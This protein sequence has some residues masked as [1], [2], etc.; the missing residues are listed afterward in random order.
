MV[1]PFKLRNARNAKQRARINTFSQLKR[2]KITPM[3]AAQAS[4]VNIQQ[5]IS[6]RCVVLKKSTWCIYRKQWS[7]RMHTRSEVEPFVLYIE[8]EQ[9]SSKSDYGRK[10]MR[11]SMN[12]KRQFSREE[13]RVNLWAHIIPSCERLIEL[14]LPQQQKT[15]VI[16]PYVPGKWSV[17]PLFPLFR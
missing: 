4:M 3:N 16:L 17:N 7:T 11:G 9:R 15:R 2:S 5:M 8:F 13:V 1:Q 10:I 6:Q 12:R 14:C